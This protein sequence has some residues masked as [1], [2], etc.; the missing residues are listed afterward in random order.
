MLLIINEKLVWTGMEG[1]NKIRPNKSFFVVQDWLQVYL[2][3]F[4]S[5]LEHT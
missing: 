1:I 2:E 3:K 4:Q 5:S